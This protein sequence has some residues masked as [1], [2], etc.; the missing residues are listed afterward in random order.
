MNQKLPI[1]EVKKLSEDRLMALPGVIGVAIG[2]TEDRLQHVI[3]V[4][5]DQRTSDLEK[6]IPNQIEG[7]PVE[8]EIRKGFRAW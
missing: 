6:Q 4:Y 2:T 8:I 3:K 1:E 7:Y 5:V